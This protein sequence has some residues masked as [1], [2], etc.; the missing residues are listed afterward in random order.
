M[1]TSTISSTI[2]RPNPLEDQAPIRRWMQVIPKTDVPE[3]DRAEDIVHEL[4]EG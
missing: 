4:R 3:S 2:T 1:S